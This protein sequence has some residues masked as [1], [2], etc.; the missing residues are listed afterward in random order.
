MPSAITVYYFNLLVSCLGG[1][2][3]NAQ[4]YLHVSQ[5]MGSAAFV[6]HL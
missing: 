1:V 3:L 2:I 6:K 5:C 4:Q